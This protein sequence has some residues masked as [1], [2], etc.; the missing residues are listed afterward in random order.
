[1]LRAHPLADNQA[2]ASAAGPG[3]QLLVHE[4]AH[5]L[6]NP[7]VTIKTFAQL[8]AERYDDAA[9]RARF[10]DVV[11]SDIER[12]DELLSVLAEFAGFD[13]P[14]KHSL[15]LKEQLRS[16]IASLQEHCAKR[17]IRVGWKG[18]GHGVK[19]VADDAQ[20]Q[21]A[22]KNTI[23]A[24]LSQ[25]RS[26]SEIEVA[27]GKAGSLTISYLRDGERMPSLMNYLGDVSTNGRES[28][29][30]LRLMLA[31]EIVERSGGRLDIDYKNDHREVVIME[32]PVG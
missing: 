15:V 8:L 27:L 21:Y 17:K 13:P 22:L 12:M 10:Q 29:L 4:L 16:A 6:K 1:L 19:I 23:R 9:F 14:R 26:G 25:A 24:V 3:L 31:R 18:D 11:D 28:L 5:E 30:P 20:L 2:P 32:F 7:M